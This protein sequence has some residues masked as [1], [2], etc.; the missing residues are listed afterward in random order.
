M[1]VVNR[2]LSISSVIVFV[3]RNAPGWPVDF[4]S[5]NVEGI[6]GYSAKEFLDGSILFSDVV[7]P[8]DLLRVQGEVSINS[9][10]K[11]RTDFSHEPYRIVTKDGKIKWFD[12][13]T[14]IQRDKS[15]KIVFYEGILI[16]ITVRKLAEQ[17][18][19]ENQRKLNS[20][21]RNIPGMIYSAK[22][23]WSVDMISNS[24][25]ICGYSVYDFLNRTV[26]WID[27]IHPDDRS[28]VFN[29][30]PL[31]EKKPQS[32]IQEYRII[33]KDGTVK[34]V[35][36]HK[37]SRFTPAM[38]FDGVDGIVFDITRRKNYENELIIAKE[39]AETNEIELKERIKE[40]NGIF[41]L[42]L[43]CE[44]YENLN[45]VYNEFV[46]VIVPESFRYSEKVCVELTVNGVK[47]SNL[48][49]YERKR[50]NVC[51]SEK[52]VVYNKVVGELN[53]CYTESLPFIEVYEQNLVQTYAQRISNIIERKQMQQNILR[54]IIETEEKERKRVAQDLH[55]G[56]GPILSTIKLF[57]ETYFNSNDEN[58]KKKI[59]TQLLASINEALDQ[60]SV[61]S[62]NLTPQILIDFG[63]KT[64]IRN[65]IDNLVKV[66]S[67]KFLFNFS[68]EE[69]VCNDI[70]IT[71]YRV[72]IELI[73][74]T[75][76]YAGAD[77]IGLNVWQ[78]DGN[79]TIEY[80]DDGVGFNFAETIEKKVGMGLFNIQHR[81]NSFNGEVKFYRIKPKGIKY[82]IRIPCKA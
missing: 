38:D 11:G 36:D 43:L 59:A 29:Q 51:L 10:D 68:L 31:F 76:K 7:H 54:T 23:D 9:Q 57:T 16:D 71:I 73:N 55:D 52:I 78:D 56:L 5:T 50:E 4:V 77:S 41:R 72:V 70:E 2:I 66:S 27:V 20:L 46:E 28:L 44:K 65:F 8:N 6:M 63:L 42:G 32:I 80:T 69:N 61:I 1:L 40:L 26:S 49:G 75:M 17:M 30:G 34:Y 22:G 33:D 58:Y 47:Y 21:H 37:T 18:L 82:I 13:R 74:N 12:D 14:H 60:I 81:I 39:R 15:G 48:K 53:V 19:T 62:N 24:E 25:I 79:I 64:A 35:S 67:K 45:S 3:W